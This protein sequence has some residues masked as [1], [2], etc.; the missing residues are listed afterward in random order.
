MYRKYPILGQFWR[1]SYT[2]FNF[3][4]IF[5]YFFSL[6][7]VAPLL[8]LIPITQLPNQYKG[9]T[10]KKSWRNEEKVLNLWEEFLRRKKTTLFSFSKLSY[11][12][13][14]IFSFSKKQSRIQNCVSSTAS[15]L[16]TPS[17]CY[18]NILIWI[19]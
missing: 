11:D 7:S 8:A 12:P 10:E 2:H 4:S 16:R 3:V 9:C 15:S 1:E 13:P 5:I 6:T 18:H 14:Y 17:K 19:P